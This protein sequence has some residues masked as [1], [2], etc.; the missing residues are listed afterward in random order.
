VH[1]DRGLGEVYAVAA[2]DWPLFP[3]A[4]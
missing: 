4:S 1:I 3:A 2:R